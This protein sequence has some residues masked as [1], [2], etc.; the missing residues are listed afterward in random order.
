MSD[1]VYL[2]DLYFFVFSVGFGLCPTK[3]C[4]GYMDIPK[5]CSYC[6]GLFDFRLYAS[7]WR[8]KSS[9]K[10]CFHIK[11]ENEHTKNVSHNWSDFMFASLVGYM[12]ETWRIDSC[13]FC[14][15]PLKWCV[16][17]VWKVPSKYS[18]VV[19][20]TENITWWTMC[21]L[22]I[23]IGWIYE[24]IYLQTIFQVNVPTHAQGI[25][26]TLEQLSRIENL[27]KKHVAQDKSEL[28]MIEEQK[29]D[30]KASSKFNQDQ[31]SLGEIS[32][33]HELLIQTR[34]RKQH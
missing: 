10:N 23:L 17:S 28:Q 9:W 29:C 33:L 1:S 32:T 20:S 7:Y 3:I 19:F 21:V 8:N 15:T 22:F 18:H 25:N 13:K 27:I 24:F 4:I 12:L 2:I 5:L 31:S 34:K 6:K 14:C 26:L 11:K 30:I 16:F